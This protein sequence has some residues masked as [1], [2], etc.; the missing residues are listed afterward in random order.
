MILWFMRRKYLIDPTLFL[1]FCDYPPFKEDL[2][3]HLNKL[4]FQSC[5]ICLYQVWLKL[6]RCFILKHSFQYTNVKLVSP[7]VSP[8]LI[9][10]DHYLYKHYVRKLS[11]KYELFWFSGSQGNKYLNDF[12]PF[13]HF[14]DYL[15]FEEDLT[16][17]L[18]N[19]E[20]P[21]PKNDLY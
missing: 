1:H 9:L 7:L 4:E 18:N 21:L 2:D 8:T 10:R 17:Y 11:C 3:L 6:A 16:L 5:K 14:Y 20:F 13:L 15:L 12:T 19:L